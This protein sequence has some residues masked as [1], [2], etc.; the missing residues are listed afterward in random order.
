MDCAGSWRGEGIGTHY[1]GI[2][3][4]SFDPPHI[5]HVALVETAFAALGLPEIWVIPAGNPVHRR[6]SGYAS[7][8]VRL[9]W[10]ERIFSAHPKVMVQDWEIRCE[11]PV[12]TINT[13]RHIRNRF[14]DCNPILLLG[15]DAFAGMSHWVEYPE[16]FALCDVAVFDRAGCTCVQQHGWKMV[17]IE[18]W[19]QEVGS[20]RLLCVKHK[21]P[22]VSATAVRKQIV[23]GKSLAEMVPE[24]IRGE[25]E[26][27]YGRSGCGSN[28]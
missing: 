2:F 5:G 16:Y 9:H 27:A 14:P 20:G 6:L 4:G 8:E 10:L 19:K 28:S 11:K 21:L 7:P 23:A 12:P 17:S 26:Q 15:A 18:R 24:C 1:I 22:D 25:I 3:G 13:L